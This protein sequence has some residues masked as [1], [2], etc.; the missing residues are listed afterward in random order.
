MCLTQIFTFFVSKI[1]TQSQPSSCFQKGEKG[2]FSVSSG[3]S[4]W[5]TSWFHFWFPPQEDFHHPLPEPGHQ[6]AAWGL[7]QAGDIEGGPLPPC[8]LGYVVDS[9]DVVLLLLLR[10]K[11]NYLTYCLWILYL[12]DCWYKGWHKPKKYSCMWIYMSPIGPQ[13]NY[14]SSH[15]YFF[16]FFLEKWIKKLNMNKVHSKITFLKNIFKTTLFFFMVHGNMWSNSKSKF[17]C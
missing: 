11:F 9:L 14:I 17:S 12:D 16:K 7:Q 4:P 6:Q 3:C 1:H 5:C 8:F 13:S 2:T 10:W 15:N